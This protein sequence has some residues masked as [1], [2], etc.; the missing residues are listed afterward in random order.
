MHSRLNW[1]CPKLFYG[2]W[3]VIA[4][5]IVGPYIGGIVFYG[6]TAVVDPLASEFGWSYAQISLAMSLRGIE[7]AV[8]APLTGFLADRW[9]P[10]P[11]MFGGVTLVGLSLIL[12]GRVNSL[13]MF[14]AAFALVALGSSACTTLVPMVAVANWFRKK[15]GIASGIV[16]CGYGLGG[17]LVPVVTR[18]TDIYGWRTALLILAVGMLVI[19]SPLTLL[20]RHKPEQ[21]G[22]LPDGDTS[23][24]V[25]DAHDLAP[26]QSTEVGITVRQALKSRAFWQLLVA[27]MVQFMILTSVVTHIM[28][29]YSSIGIKRTSS[30]LIASA[31]PLVSIGGRL[32]FGWLGDRFRKRYMSSV[33]FAM[34]CLGMLSFSYI[35]VGGTGLAISFMIL[36]SIGYGG[37]LAILW[38]LMRE[39]FGRRYFGTISGL[40]MGAASLGGIVGTPLAGWVFDNR[41][42]YQ[43][44]WLA[45]AGLAAV[46]LIIMATMPQVGKQNQRS[47]GAG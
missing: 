22:Y 4:T 27:I 46:A 8:L 45:F 23:S 21:Y 13:G 12:L 44:I 38:P 36:F 40:L 25:S 14:Y 34:L 24:L 47:G 10:R 29:Y 5:F 18:L 37:I 30:S 26:A 17:L 42:S 20:F 3:I 31:I 6:F 7:G 16:L 1:R 15:I 9:G 33:A 39:N 19:G 32:G 28:P 35:G 2:W 41:G 43:P 11:L